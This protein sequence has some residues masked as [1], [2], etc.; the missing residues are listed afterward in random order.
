[1]GEHGRNGKTVVLELRTIY[2]RG[3]GSS[4]VGVPAMPRHGWLNRLLLLSS[5]SANSSERFASRVS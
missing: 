3:E 2:R 5:F 1:M 4:R